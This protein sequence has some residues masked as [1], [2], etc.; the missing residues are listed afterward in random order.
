LLG[1][2]EQIALD[3]S[4][5][6]PLAFVSTRALVA[7]YVKGYVDNAVHVHPT[8]WMHLEK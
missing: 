8:R 4:A 2:A 3:D 6:A 7:P 5:V 1:R